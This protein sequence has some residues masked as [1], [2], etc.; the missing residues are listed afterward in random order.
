MA[1]QDWC[2]R[3]T[4][5]RMIGEPKT[6]PEDN[7]SF[8]LES[9]FEEGHEIHRKWQRW[10]WE[11]GVLF[12]WWK[13]IG[14]DHK[15]EGLSPDR[16]PHCGEDK[17][18]IEYREVPIY[19][20]DLMVIGHSDGAIHDN[21]GKVLIEVKSIGVGTLRFDAPLLHKQY[22]EKTITLQEVWKKIRKPFNSHLRQGLIYLHLKP[23]Y[24]AIV[25]IYEFKPNQQAQEFV[26]RRNDAIIAPLLASCKE[27]KSALR[28]GFPPRRPDWAASA[29]GPK[30]KSCPYRSTCWGLEIK[31]ADPPQ[32]GP[33]IRIRRPTS[34]APGS[35]RRLGVAKQTR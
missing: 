14:C 30:C 31:D 22:T 16:C 33:R 21:K 7:P 24:E 10:F 29:D 13:C 5:F 32:A 1:K 4:F 23:E 20:E 3:E 34:G 17:D 18:L 9:I 27:I 6:D 12:G 2:P 35:G 19:D 8:N 15:W 11:M 28:S 25:F 26:V